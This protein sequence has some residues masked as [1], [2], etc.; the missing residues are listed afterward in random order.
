PDDLSV[1][2]M[3]YISAEIGKYFIIPMYSLIAFMSLLLWKGHVLMQFTKVYS[4]QSLV[5]QE[6]ENWPAIAPVSNLDLVAI[7]SLKGPWAM[8]MTP[9]QFCKRYKL[10]ELERV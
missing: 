1:P 6:Q 5:K 9:M 8:A 7:D 3:D 2:L 4:M 10:L